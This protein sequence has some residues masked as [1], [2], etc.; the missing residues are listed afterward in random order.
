MDTFLIPGRTR[1]PSAK[2]PQTVDVDI[3]KSLLNAGTTNKSPRSVEAHS[4]DPRRRHQ[5][6]QL[7]QRGT[8]G[9]SFSALSD[10]CLNG[11]SSNSE[12]SSR[13]TS[14]FQLQ[15]QDLADEHGLHEIRTLG[16]IDGR[17][18]F[19]DIQTNS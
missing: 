9:Q 14:V 11:L 6:S 16:N 18:A 3:T 8:S 19:L 7:V 13:Q 10:L 12:P 17:Q 5:T 2:I 15:Y 1:Y 4:D